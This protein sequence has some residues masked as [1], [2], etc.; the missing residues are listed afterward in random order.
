MVTEVFVFFEIFIFFSIPLLPLFPCFSL[1]FY[2]SA[3]VVR[4]SVLDYKKIQK[5]QKI[6]I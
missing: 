5:K 1:S 6:W 4:D 3:Y 2:L